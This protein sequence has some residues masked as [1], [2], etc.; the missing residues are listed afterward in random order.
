MEKNKLIRLNYSSNQ[1]Q[2]LVSSRVLIIGL[3]GV[4]GLV[5]EALVRSG[6]VNIDICDGDKVE[7]SNFNRQ[8]IANKNTLGK[9]KVDACE[10]K[11][12][13]ICDDLNIVKFNF[14]IDE[15]TINKIDFSKYDIVVDCIDDVNAKILIIE[16]CKNNDIEIISSMGTANKND[17]N[18]FKIMDINQTSYC[19]LAKKVRTE[20]RKK[21]INNVKVCFSNEVPTSNNMLV[22]Q[23]YIVGSASFVIVKYVIDKLINS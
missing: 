17:P 16:K 23:M 13:S 20:L 6:I 12:L 14:M 15:E 2:K 18:G 21:Q 1:M 10:E 22:S 5:C 11:M 3:G 4:G 7:E 19:P 8:V 9:A